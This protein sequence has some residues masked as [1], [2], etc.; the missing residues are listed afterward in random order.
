MPLQSWM[1]ST[2]GSF[3]RQSPY[4]STNI[5]YSQCL[6]PLLPTVVLILYLNTLIL[7]TAWESLKISI[8]LIHL[9]IHSILRKSGMV[10]MGTQHTFVNFQNKIPIAKDKKKQR[11][12]KSCLP[13]GSSCNLIVSVKKMQVGWGGWDW[14]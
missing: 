12:E 6:H 8:C 5:I 11:L 1:P 9:C 10:P 4:Y 2:L 14:I 3:S 7:P 13:E